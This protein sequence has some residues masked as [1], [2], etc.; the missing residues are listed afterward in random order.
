MGANSGRNAA[1]PMMGGIANAAQPASRSLVP[2]PARIALSFVPSAPRFYSYT[3]SAGGSSKQANG[4]HETEVTA[5]KVLGTSEASHQF[6]KFFEGLRR[7]TTSP[8][9][10]GTKANGS[11][12]DRLVSSVQ[13]IG[14]P[15][16]MGIEGLASGSSAAGTAL[17]A[18]S[19]RQTASNSLAPGA[20]LECDRDTDFS[21]DLDMSSARRWAEAQQGWGL[22]GFGVQFEDVAAVPNTSPPLMRY[23]ATKDGCVEKLQDTQQPAHVPAVAAAAMAAVKAADA[24]NAL[25]PNWEQREK[26]RKDQETDPGA[27]YTNGYADGHPQD[28]QAAQCSNGEPLPGGDHNSCEPSR[29]ADSSV[30][31]PAANASW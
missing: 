24:K 17:W 11:T 4:G 30:E 13:S 9:L 1:Y 8:L 28:M 26:E 15:G 18:Y 31:L 25:F 10:K 14:P 16:S 29:P 12:E 7:P 27:E 3:P 5:A 19:S 20:D 22:T 23:V 21:H 2:P 6:V